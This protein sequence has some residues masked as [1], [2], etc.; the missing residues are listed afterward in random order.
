M[1]SAAAGGR[2]ASR[3]RSGTVD[4]S[5]QEQHSRVKASAHGTPILNV[6][7]VAGTG[8]GTGTETQSGSS[9]SRQEE[10]AAAICAS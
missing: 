3:R 9:R 6:R 10:A 2:Q 4:G 7:W 8:A 5:S 1:G